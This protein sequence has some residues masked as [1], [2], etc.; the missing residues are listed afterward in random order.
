MDNETWS[1]EAIPAM[2]ASGRKR[3]YNTA[4][5]EYGSKDREPPELPQESL[6]EII[7]IESKR[8]QYAVDT[9]K[10][11]TDTKQRLD[12][13]ITGAFAAAILVGGI[14][15]RQT[16]AVNE[17]VKE[18][19]AAHGVSFDGGSLASYGEAAAE[20]VEH[21]MYNTATINLSRELSGGL[22]HVSEHWGSCPLCAPYQGL[23]YSTDPS[24]PHY[25]YLYDTPYSE[26]YGNF[27]PRCRH[28]V[29][30]YIEE[31]QSPEEVAAMRE[32]SNRSTEIGGE[33]WTKEET[34]KAKR[35]LEAYR[36]RQTRNR[37]VYD[38]RKQFARYQAVL[39]DKAPKSFAGF[40]RSKL[41]D[42]KAWRELQTE[43]RK[44]SHATGLQDQLA[45]EYN[46]SKAYI[47]KDAVITNVRTIAGK[48][49]TREIDDIGRV[50]NTYGGSYDE[51]A[52]K[53]GKIES[54][55]YVFDIHWYER[56]GMQYETKIKYMKENGK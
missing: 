5:Q 31:L 48:T 50:S 18:D 55:R 6:D 22:V 34:K 3:A 33:G 23:V 49:S 54:D 35:S 10:A 13:V 2:Y 9:G 39:G 24:D 38:D 14:Y 30:L 19:V 44:Y 16:R 7:D 25:P 11:I 4:R 15:S 36:T 43:Y 12:H 20:S 40:R 51:W 8:S 21:D 52:K 29:T 26:A 45:F 32:K 1:E 47:P 46:G 41:A 17:T 56:D 37:G 42:G 53:V 28:V 27:H